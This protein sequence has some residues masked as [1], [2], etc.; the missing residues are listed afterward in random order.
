LADISDD[1]IEE[2]LL[3]MYEPAGPTLLCAP[4]GVGKGSTGAYHITQ[5][6]ALG[7]KP[8]IYDAERRPREWARR[9]SGLGGDR[10][11]VVYLEPSDLPKHLMGKPLWDVAP[12]LGQVILSAGADM[13]FVDSI[14]PSVGVGEE[15]L[16]SDAQ[17]P[18]LYVAALDELAIP[19]A[20][21]AHPPK[22]QPDG[23]PFGSV[24][25]VNAM[26][27]T[28]GG[29][30]AES[31]G[32]QVRWRPKKRNERGHI[33]G[34]LLTFDYGADGRLCNVIE[35]DDEEST[36][37]WILG[38]LVGGPRTVA[39]MTDIE[40][41]QSDDLLTDDAMRRNKARLAKAVGRMVELGTSRS[42][43]VAEAGTSATPSG[44]PGD[45]VRVQNLRRGSRECPRSCPS[46]H[47]PCP[48]C[49]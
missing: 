15:R 7:M 47:G 45:G 29:T 24:S 46:S 38:A 43:A 32:H 23:D 4:G 25:W 49:A 14:L 41:E 17:V 19:S 40:A 20:S 2:L 6:L 31:T 10:S 21:F 48:S 5:L 42:W 34:V 3:G 1:P 8:M 27:L 28:W 12:Y 13:L 16:K 44:R 18:Y 37:E 30:R 33:P 36:R 11:Q 35:E 26:R 22:G 9:V 39:E